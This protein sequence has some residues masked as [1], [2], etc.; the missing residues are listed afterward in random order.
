MLASKF[1]GHDVLCSLT[2]RNVDSKNSSS[3]SVGIPEPESSQSL[4]TV[5][6]L[7]LVECG[8]LRVHSPFILKYQNHVKERLFVSSEP[9]EKYTSSLSVRVLISYITEWK[10]TLI[11]YTKRWSLNFILTRISKHNSCR[12][13]TSVFFNHSGTTEHLLKTIS[14]ILIK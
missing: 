9:H 6:Q 7:K 2:A 3:G 10:S 13:F 8:G 14:H 5:P 4:V 1:V 12:H 11:V